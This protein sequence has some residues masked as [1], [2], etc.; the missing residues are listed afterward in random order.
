MKTP[1]RATPLLMAYALLD[2]LGMLVF[3]SGAMWLVKRQPLLIAGFPDSPTNALL[4]V[5]TGAGLMWWS[6]ARIMR[7]LIEQGPDKGG[8]GDGN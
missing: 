6:A 7:E 4:A 5:A 1:P 8:G 3:A 2:A